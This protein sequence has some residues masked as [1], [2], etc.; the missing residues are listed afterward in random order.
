MLKVLQYFGKH[1]F[2]A[3]TEAAQVVESIIV[4]GALIYALLR[5]MCYL[6]AAQMNMQFSLIQ[7]LM[8]SSLGWAIT[9]WKQPKTFDMQK[10]KVQSIR[11]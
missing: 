4:V 9:P 6:K 11:A 8:F 2:G 7:E 10:V 5:A 3:C 1:F